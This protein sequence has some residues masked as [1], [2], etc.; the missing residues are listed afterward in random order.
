MRATTVESRE[1]RVL[2]AALLRCR[3]VLSAEIESEP[4]Q[5]SQAA[6]RLAIAR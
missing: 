2:I 3:I 5:Q 6:Q 1:S 4:S